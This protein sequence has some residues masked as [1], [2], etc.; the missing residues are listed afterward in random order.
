MTEKPDI[1]ARWIKCAFFTGKLCGI[2]C[3]FFLQ[4]FIRK[5]HLNYQWDCNSWSTIEVNTSCVLLILTYRNK[6]PHTRSHIVLYHFE[7]RRRPMK[8]SLIK[9]QYFAIFQ[10]EH[11]T[12]IAVCSI[13]LRMKNA[14]FWGSYL[15]HLTIPTTATSW[16]KISFHMNIEIIDLLRFNFKNWISKPLR[17]H[18]TPSMTFNTPINSHSNYIVLNSFFHEFFFR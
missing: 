3:F 18:T 10:Y 15:E 13:F 14:L 11:W 1:R 5:F 7:R 12:H 2:P 9:S 6:W 17:T 4:N 8:I 16:T